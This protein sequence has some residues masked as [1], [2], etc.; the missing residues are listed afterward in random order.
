[1]QSPVEVVG[2]GRLVEGGYGLSGALTAVRVRPDRSLDARL[3]ERFRWLL[4]IPAVAVVGLFFGG[5]GYV[6]WLLLQ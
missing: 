4:L 2:H 3:G 6:A 5:I 1:M